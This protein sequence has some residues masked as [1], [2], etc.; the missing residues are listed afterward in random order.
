MLSAPPLAA[1]SFFVFP[2]Q[3][4]GGGN[5]QTDGAAE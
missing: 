4:R 5:M 2:T 3:G 1:R